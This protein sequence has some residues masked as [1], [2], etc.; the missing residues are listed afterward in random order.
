MTAAKISLRIDRIVT[1]T[2]GFSRAALEVALHQ[3][4]NAHYAAHGAA[5]FGQGGS[6]AQVRG[7]MASGRGPLSGR[8]AAAVVK[9][10]TS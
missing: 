8:V 10:V 9:A 4:L 2:P 1:E 3:A 7:D 5:G 6:R